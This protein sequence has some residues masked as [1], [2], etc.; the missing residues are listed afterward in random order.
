MD[1]FIARVESAAAEA[2]Q[3]AAETAVSRYPKIVNNYWYVWDT[4]VGDFVN[5]GVSADG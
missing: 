3:T 2:A 4:A 5:T 1:Q